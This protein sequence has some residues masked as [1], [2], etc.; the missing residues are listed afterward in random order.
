M[1][2]KPIQ[3]WTIGA[4]AI[5]Y[6]SCA[7]CGGKQYFRREFCAACGSKD[8]TEHRASGQGVVYAVSL[9]SRAATPEARAHGP[10]AIVLVDADEGFRLMAHGAQNLVIGDRV[11]ARYARFTDRLVPL[12]ERML[13]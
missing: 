2:T 5:V 8:L 3:D 9:V 12:F 6:Q 7:G 4:E 10:Y 11:T 1:S 13:P